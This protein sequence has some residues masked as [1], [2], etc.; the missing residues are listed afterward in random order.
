MLGRPF[1]PTGG[2]KRSEIVLKVFFIGIVVHFRSLIVSNSREEKNFFDVRLLGKKER[3]EKRKIVRFNQRSCER[4][5]LEALYS[6][7]KVLRTF[8]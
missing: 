3:M 4:P 8:L 2:K 5:Q 6:K 1:L 7:E